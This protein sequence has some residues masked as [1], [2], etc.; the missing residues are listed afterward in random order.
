MKTNLSLTVLIILFTQAGLLATGCANRN[1]ADV[2]DTGMQ[3]SSKV[4]ENSGE[5]IGVRNK[6]F[7]LQKKKNLAE[8]LR[9]L[10]EKVR[11][12]DDRVF[13]S[14]DYETYG[15][16]GQLRDCRNK[17]KEKNSSLEAGSL[18][19][20]SDG[21]YL[22]NWKAN[23]DAK[24]GIEKTTDKLVALSE[25]DLDDHI[26][27]LNKAKVKLQDKEDELREKLSQCKTATK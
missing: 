21:D 26:K 8:E 9:T 23:G 14:R 4:S 18:E 10:E 12:L 22:L 1:K 13:G 6:E 20:M 3:N 5:A 11:E 7:V 19:R 17:L 15:L 27:K 24:A 25:E 2:I 16:W